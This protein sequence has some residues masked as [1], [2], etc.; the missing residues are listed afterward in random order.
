MGRQKKDDEHLNENY[1]GSWQ[2]INKEIVR[3]NQTKY[4][5]RLEEGRKVKE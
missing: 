4:G 5:L 3:K 2:P 1:K